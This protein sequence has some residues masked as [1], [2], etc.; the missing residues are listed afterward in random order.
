MDAAPAG[1]DNDTD[2]DDLVEALDDLESLQRDGYDH[3]IAHSAN[4]KLR[5]V[6]RRNNIGIITDELG[7]IVRGADVPEADIFAVPGANT[8]LHVLKPAHAELADGKTAPVPANDP[9]LIAGEVFDKVMS[10]DGTVFHRRRPGVFAGEPYSFR[11]QASRPMREDEKLKLAGLLGYA[12]ASGVRGE[13]FGMPE[14][15]SPY[16]FVV[17]VDTTKSRSD[18]VGHAMQRF[19][20]APPEMILEG[21]AP[22]KTDRKGPIG[23]RLVEGFNEPGLGIEL[24]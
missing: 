21:S 6:L 17:S 18:D 3:S 1:L 15:D 13:G 11:V 22:R 7:Q 9:R 24:Y 2:A 14:S 16:S 12:Y 10:P 23:S 4:G 20:E 5:A 19:E 8:L